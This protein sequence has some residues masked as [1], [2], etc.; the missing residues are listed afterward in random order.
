MVTFLLTSALILS[1]LVVAVYFWQKPRTEPESPML[2]PHS[3]ARGLFTGEQLPE[4]DDRLK[5]TS[6]DR[7]TEIIR[8]AESGEKNALHD[9]HAIGDRSFYDRVL[10]IL[11]VE[12]NSDPQLL[13]LISFVTRSELPVNTQL[14]T[15]MLESWKNS[16]DRSGTAKTL[17]IVAL[18]NDASLYNMA[19]EEALQLWRA[20]RLPDVSAQELASLLDGEFWLLSSEVRG[21]GDGFLLK[22]TLAKARGELKTDAR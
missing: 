12:A 11:S 18:S 17:H 10:G 7:K 15:R 8:A 13:S 4:F 3:G 9:A 2:P 21:S 22:R 6:A 16:P 20:G 14:A 19:V 1:I 5:L